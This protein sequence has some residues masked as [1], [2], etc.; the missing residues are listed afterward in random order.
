MSQ[1]K[2]TGAVKAKLAKKAPALVGRIT[3]SAMSENERRHHAALKSAAEARFNGIDFAA[4]KKYKE[5][6]AARGN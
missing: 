3:H 4:L 5:R 1:I 2:Y 6:T